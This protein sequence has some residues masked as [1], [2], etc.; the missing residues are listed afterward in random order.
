MTSAHPG[1]TPSVSGSISPRPLSLLIWLAIIGIALFVTALVLLHEFPMMVSGTARG[2][3]P[4]RILVLLLVG[5]MGGVGLFCYGFVLGQKKRLV[6]TTPTSA[7]RSLAVGL[8]EIIGTAEPGGPPLRAP[9][10]QLPCVFFSYRV[11]EQQGSGDHRRWKTIAEG[12]SDQPFGTRDATG[13]V[14][15]FPQ[16]ADLMLQD[17]RTYRNDWLG[18]LPLS[19]TTGLAALGIAGAGWLGQ[20]TLRCHE[21]CLLSGAPVYVLGTAQ[22]NTA[23]QNSIN[24]SRLFIGRARD[25]QLLIS[26]RMEQ[27]LLTRWGWQ[28]PLCLWSGPAVTVA[29]LFAISQWYLRT[30]H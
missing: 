14:Q 24:E 30:G 9:F 17:A 22:E 4:D 11:E 15:V 26:D 27:D 13:I 19:V 7:I 25:G 3:A 1:S 12:T 2:R 23:A 18:A 20:K 6:E 28:I 5:M 21:S 16:G 29:C 10:S 8:V